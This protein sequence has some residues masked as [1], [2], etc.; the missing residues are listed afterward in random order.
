MNACKL[1]LITMFSTIFSQ[2]YDVEVS[3]DA[4]KITEEEKYILS[5][6]NAEIKNYFVSN[7]FCPEYD[8]LDIPLKIQFIHES[9]NKS[10]NKLNIISQVLISDYND[11]YFFSGI[12]FSYHS[13][14]SLTFNPL[15]YESLPAFLNYYA[16]LFIGYELDTWG[17]NSGSEY[18]SKSLDISNEM[19]FSKQSSKD[20]EKRKSYVKE[21]LNNPKL[22]NIRYLYYYLKYDLLENY[23]SN[24][25]IDI[26]T[27]NIKIKNIANEIFEDLVFIYEKI[28]YD[29]NTLKFIDNNS[30]DLA[31][32][33]YNEKIKG[34]IDFL[35]LFDEKN[36]ETYK[37]YKK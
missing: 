18:Y 6:F 12:S 17:L 22:R 14:K 27:L 37:N 20:W 15:S 7:N 5:N 25:K 29:K 13:G 36:V 8:Y 24:D 11:Q 1:I 31:K 2:F 33:F 16:Y 3:M 32:L 30:L 19:R 4:Q 23:D 34:S 28:G 21:I 26:D 10:G 9:I 35:I